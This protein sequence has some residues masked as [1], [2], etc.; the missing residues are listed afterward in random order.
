MNHVRLLEKLK[1]HRVSGTVLLWFADYLSGRFQQVHVNGSSG[2]C[3]PVLKGVPQ[4]S[5]LGPTLF[6]MYVSH[7]PS[8]VQHTS[9]EVPSYADDLTVF[10]IHNSPS[11]AIQKITDALDI[12]SADLQENGLTLNTSKSCGMI[13]SKDDTSLYSIT[14]NGQALQTVSHTRLLG[15]EIDDGL[16]WEPQVR[17]MSAKIGRKIGTL[18]IAKRHL[19]SQAKRLFLSSAILLDFDYACTSFATGI[20]SAARSRLAALERRALQVACDARYTEDNMFSIV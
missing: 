9:A 20:S 1:S 10:A 16:S 13:I 17:M 11:C 4:G 2:V 15:P 6:N 3:A 14:C 18:K 19:S 12:I 8:I 5:V 7:V